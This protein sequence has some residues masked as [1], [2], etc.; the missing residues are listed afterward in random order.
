MFRK[1]GK[2]K[3]AF[4][5]AILFGISLFFFRGSSKYSNLFNSDNVIASVS[6]T[7]I[8]TTKFNRVMNMNIS[9]YSQMLG[10]ELN[11]DEIK[12]FQ[13]H[14]V[15][16]N[17]L[18]NNAIFEN[19]F[20]NKEF[21]ID[22]SVVAKKTKERIPGIYNNENKLN[23]TALNNFLKN[24]NLKIDD[25][26][27]IIN[28]ETRATVFD[29][30]FFNVNYPSQ[31]TK[32]ISIYD[33]HSRKIELIN[34]SINK[35]KIENVNLK[36]ISIDNE[37]IKKYYK[38]NLN[39]YM[40]NEMR[41]VSYILIDKKD[42]IDQFTPTDQQ[43]KNYYNNNQK[44]FIEPEKRDFIQFNFKKVEDAKEFKNKIYGLNNQ[45]IIKF[46]N[47]KN[48]IFSE[49][50]GVYENEVYEDLSK[51]IFKLKKNE[52][53][54]I[55]ETPIA[56]HVVILN[57]IIPQNIKSYDKSKNEI[58]K[59]LLDI[60]L[61]NY[62]SDLKNNISQE[63]INGYSLKEI[64]DNN[65]LKINSLLKINNKN[66][67]LSDDFV[68]NEIIRHS[69][70][71]NKDFVS[72][73]I[74]LDDDKS[75][76]LNV[77]N[78]YPSIPFKIEEIINKVGNDWIKSEKIKA[79]EDLIDMHKNDVNPLESISKKTN[80]DIK[81]ILIEKN[82]TDIPINFLNQLFNTKIYETAFS[83]TEE[84]VFIAQINE[85]IIENNKEIKSQSILLK[86]QLKN[87]FGNEI[88]KTKKISTN[89]SLLNALLS[90]Y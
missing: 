29:E 46:A 81:S 27:N 14:T 44:L 4:V 85:L 7:P 80:T 42:Y 18:I 82:N 67:D 3:I 30:L 11:S 78:V 79:I 53:S 8:S 51:I 64:S 24:Q 38:Q 23:D 40:T 74:D 56:K 9:K 12:A 68:K 15:S 84:E 59:T 83:F 50:N 60:E 31:I 77:D 90:Q 41:D 58:F 75:L 52:V 65:S 72:D 21:I 73:L 71:S 5:L 36:N 57:N 63:I 19:E 25:L 20:Q 1:L 87:A 61:N 69:F 26:V 55:I 48:I 76:I 54:D 34:F 49:F 70:I 45:E 47:N 86:P 66:D 13:I 39:N 35:F 43:I 28:Y 88:I 10:K 32:K 62:F 89:D 33:D 6:G 17:G 16:L 37:E 2:S 22:D